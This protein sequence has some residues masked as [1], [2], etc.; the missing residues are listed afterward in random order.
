MH[1]SR[2]VYAIERIIT[3]LSYF[4]AGIAGFV[5]LLIAAILKKQVTTFIWYH[6]FQ[7]IFLSFL[8]FIFTIVLQ[9]LMSIP[10]INIIPIHFYD[11]INCPIPILYG[12][13]LLQ[14]FT[15]SV[16][17]YAIVTSL[18]GQ[19]TYIPWVS[20]IIKQNLGIGR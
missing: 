19:Y 5:W 17:L 6:T 16:M 13:S 15:T 8:Y 7:S 3:A 18:C 1:P 10:I 12:L 14:T 2:N 9:L 4:T 11:F 20:G